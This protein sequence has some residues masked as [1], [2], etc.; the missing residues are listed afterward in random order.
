MKI[1][2]RLL[3]LHP[4]VLVLAGCSVFGYGSVD[5]ATYEVLEKADG[6]EVRYYERLV[7]VTTA[8]PGGMEEQKEPF[9]KLFD[10]ISGNNVVTEQIPM[11]AP[12]FIEQADETA[13][14]MAFVLPEKFSVETAP[15]PKD[16]TV[17]VEELVE[18]TVAAITFNGAFEQDAINRHKN[19]LEQWIAGQGL[20][21]NGAVIAAGYN[22]PFTLPAF[23][24]NEVL[25]PVIHP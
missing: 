11:T 23:R 22:P 3:L 14:S 24:R 20:Q 9:M 10:Y 15:V 1:F 12:V 7:L 16:P 19:I 6:I 21:K 5:M 17:Q 13:E 25:I 8:M 18:F 2:S 4:C